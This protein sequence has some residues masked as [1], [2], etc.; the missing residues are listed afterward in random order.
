VSPRLGDSP[1]L[2]AL[3]ALLVLPGR[4]VSCKAA[5]R[6]ILKI[7]K[8][9]I[10]LVLAASSKA[11]L[12][13]PRPLVQLLWHAHTP[14]PTLCANVSVAQSLQGTHVGQVQLAF[15][16]SQLLPTEQRWLYW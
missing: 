14:L 11:A 16:L 2:A 3:S 9:V 6:L 7:S 15:L 12:P 8:Q 5:S 13:S 1:R 4:V 10:S